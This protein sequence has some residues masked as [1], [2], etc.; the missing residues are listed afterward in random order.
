MKFDFHCHSYFSDG[1]LSP[2]ALLDYALEREIELLA[3][4]D[5]DCV[6]GLPVMS[7]YISDN[8]INIRLINGIEISALTDFGEIHIVGLNIEPSC[9]RLNQRLDAQMSER[10]YRAEAIDAKLIKL[11]VTGVLQELKKNVHQVVTR[12]HMARALVDLGY[13]KDLQQA[14]K[15][16]LGKQGKVKARKCWMTMEEAIELIINAGGIPVLAH[17]TRYPLSNRKLALLIEDFKNEGGQG[18]ELSYPSLNKD[19]QD[20]LKIHCQKNNLLASSGSDFHYP[21]LRWTDL[22]RFPQLDANVPHVL[23]HLSV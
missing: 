10:W 2:Q 6:S 22:G 20:W 17:P 18:L 3:L 23:E 7:Q 21:D 15:K 16:Y 4:T 14:F 5:H 19:K 8:N 11:G 9:S 12:S 1:L 13:V